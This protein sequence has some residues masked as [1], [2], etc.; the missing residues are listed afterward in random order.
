M[1]WG[2]GRVLPSSELPWV[3]LELHSGLPS[4]P[5]LGVGGIRRWGGCQGVLEPP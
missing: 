5:D 4:S 3:A 1:P 2:W